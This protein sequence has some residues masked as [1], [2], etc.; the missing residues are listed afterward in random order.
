MAAELKT[1]HDLT[2]LKGGLLAAEL[3]TRKTRIG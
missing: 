1:A 2:T 3:N